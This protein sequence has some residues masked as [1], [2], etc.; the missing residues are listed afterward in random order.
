MQICGLLF[1]SSL[2]VP[3]FQR[4]QLVQ[5]NFFSILLAFYR[6]VC[7]TI[8][9]LMSLLDGDGRWF[10]LLAFFYWT[11]APPLP[12]APSVP[13][14]GSAD[15][16]ESVSWPTGSC[17]CLSVGLINTYLSHL[18]PGRGLGWGMWPPPLLL[19]SSTPTPSNI[20]VAA[21]C[22]HYRQIWPL[23]WVFTEFFV[24]AQVVSAIT[25]VVWSY[26]VP[27]L[28]KRYRPKRT[29]NGWWWY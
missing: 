9:V 3:S 15:E 10:Y 2:I 17:L 26:R 28:H 29:T 4:Y 19:T 27:E 23:Y 24:P 16:S 14:Y 7:A 1:F 6:A 5:S 21:V 25:S 20:P 12:S 13:V 11:S 18:Y 8:S 22:C